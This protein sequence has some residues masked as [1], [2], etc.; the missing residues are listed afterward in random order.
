M[1]SSMPYTEKRATVSLKADMAEKLKA[2]AAQENRSL[3]GQVNQLIEESLARRQGAIPLEDV[4]DQFKKWGVKGVSELI[5][6]A[7]EF[8]QSQVASV[9]AEEEQQARNLLLKL[10]NGESPTQPE[11]CK[12]ANA[13]GT[14]KSNLNDLIRKVE[15]GESKKGNGQPKA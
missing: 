6:K 14:S 8:L 13:L 2:L 7:F 15:N 12:L 5:G 1:E 11:L 3:N 10:I 9:E 4:I